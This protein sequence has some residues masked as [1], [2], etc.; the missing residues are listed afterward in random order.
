MVRS[1]I[2]SSEEQRQVDSWGSLGNHKSKVPVLLENYS[3][4]NYRITSGF[5]MHRKKERG[6]ETDTYRETDREIDTYRGGEER[7]THTQR[8]RSRSCRA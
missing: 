8:E 7:Q 2:P 6:R 5:L 1:Y 4:G 3:R